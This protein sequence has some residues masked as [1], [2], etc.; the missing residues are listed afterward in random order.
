MKWLLFFC[1]A[2]ILT[3]PVK[4]PAD[5]CFVVP[6]F[7]WD[8]HKDINEPPQKAIIVYDAGREDLTLQ[9]KYDGPMDEFGWLIPV[10]NLPTVEIG[11]MKC[12]YELSQYTQRYEQTNHM[13]MAMTAV[14]AP[15]HDEPPVKVIEIKT[16]GAYEIAVLSPHDSGSL[17]KW[18]ADNQ[19]FF[20][21][22]KAGVLDSYVRRQWYFV[23]V[24]INLA[25]SFFSKM[26]TASDLASGE[27]NPLQISFASDRCV[28]PLKISSV[29]DRPSAVQVYVLSPEPL[30]EKT[31]F[32]QKLPF[33]YSNDIARVESLEARVQRIQNDIA[34]RNEED[35]DFSQS[36]DKFKVFLSQPPT[37]VPNDLSWYAK[38]SSHDLPVCASSIPLLEQ[39]SFWTRSQKTWWLTKQ[40]W[41]FE[42]QEMRDLLFDPAIP[43]FIATL[44]SKYG[45]IAANSLW[46]FDAD[47]IPA[48]LTALR[49]PIPA[50]RALAAEHLGNHS[51][52]PRVQ[53][54]AIDCLRDSE[55][56]V[57]Q[58]GVYVL[59]EAR[60]KYPWLYKKLVF[61]LRDPDAEVREAV[62]HLLAIPIYRDNV[63]KF[64]PEFHEMLKDTNQMVRISGLRVIQQMGTPIGRDE[65][66][67]FLKIPDRLAIGIAIG[68]FRDFQREDTYYNLSDQDAVA[69][70]QNKVPLGRQLGLSILYQNAEKQSVELALPLLKDPEKGLRYR[71]AATLRALTGQH[72]TEGQADQWQAW[73]AVNQTNFVAQPHPDELR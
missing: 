49:S 70:L 53:E 50:V 59:W 33:I 27:L 19:Y 68:Y 46:L 14:D 62:G 32:E 9:V 25:Q 16:V 28:F 45:Y 44:D 13:G 55:P 65:L 6:K 63:Q 43:V 64:L 39:N 7:V 5:G 3:A 51:L 11:S 30:V 38:V 57:R 1:L 21:T 10:P 48:L 15:K 23:A 36:P 42:P 56:R 22:N 35:G 52:D 73:W 37:T 40:T 47:A 54:A 60:D 58:A 20:P 66:L 67:P 12:F 4:S 26:F 61:L 31:M 18:L 72:F 41:T 34:R 17:E 71:A 8:K 29:N 69:L 24:K 2:I